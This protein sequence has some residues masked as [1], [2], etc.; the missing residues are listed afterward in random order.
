MMTTCVAGIVELTDLIRYRLVLFG[1]T[2]T[3]REDWLSWWPTRGQG[4]RKYQLTKRQ[5]EEQ[6][7]QAA[8]SAG[9]P[10][11]ALKLARKAKLRFEYVW[12]M[13]I[14]ESMSRGKYLFRGSF[15]A[16]DPSRLLGKFLIG[17]LDDVGVPINWYLKN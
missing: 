12:G 2:W 8:M 10:K 17:R 4:W 7:I 11:L 3:G 6:A 13:S 9:A 14:R 15:N 5:E 16:I 1:S